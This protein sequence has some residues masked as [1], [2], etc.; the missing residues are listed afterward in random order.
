VLLLISHVL[1]QS[2]LLNNFRQLDEEG[3]L[4]FEIRVEVCFKFCRVFLPIGVEVYLVLQK[5][6]RRGVR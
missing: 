5:I 4:F 6:A 3:V 2:P 1:V